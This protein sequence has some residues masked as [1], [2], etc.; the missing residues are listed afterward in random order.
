M[1]TRIAPLDDMSSSTV[2]FVTVHSESKTA[3]YWEDMSEE[4]RHNTHLEHER[5]RK[6]THSVDLQQTRA[7][8]GGWAL[9]VGYFSKILRCASIP[10]FHSIF[11]FGELVS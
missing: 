9:N 1:L 8:P 11:V 2:G 4:L 10:V 7:D 3:F 5:T 6:K